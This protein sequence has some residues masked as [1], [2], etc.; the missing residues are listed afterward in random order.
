MP[1]KPDAIIPPLTKAGARAPRPAHLGHRQR[2]V[3]LPQERR[4]AGLQAHGVRRPRRRGGARHRA[5]L[6]DPAGRKVCRPP[7]RRVAAV[8]P[9]HPVQRDD[10]LVPA[11][12]GA[13]RGGAELLGLRDRGRRRRF[14]SAGDSRRR[15]RTRSAT[16][17]AADSVGT[18]ADP[19]S[20]RARGQPIAAAVNARPS[21]F[22][23]GRNS[24]SP[25]RLPSWVAPRAASR[26]TAPGGS[27]LG[28]GLESQ[29]NHTMNGSSERCRLLRGQRSTARHW[30]R[31]WRCASPARS[32]ER[33][34]RPAAR[35]RRAPAR[36]PRAGAVD[37]ARAAA[38]AA[39]P[40]L[41]IRRKA[42]ARWPLSG[43]PS[44]WLR[45]A[46][47]APL[48]LLLLGLL[49]IER[50]YVDQQVRAAAEID[51]A[52]LTDDLPPQPT[53]TRASP[54]S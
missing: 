18:G 12:E 54:S 10:G 22:V 6:D 21:C 53:A 31:A 36:R 25:R 17:S 51:A 45:L 29:G 2:T 37:R 20:D 32:A 7:R 49:F 26:P 39:A 47:L 8:V 9:A 38:Q 14:R 24:M 15:R 5:G 46:S 23:T 19:A 11:P 35:H 44:W 3:R 52:L 50:S 30:R 40:R 48:A 42:A 27:C 16:E 41:R 13:Q 1:G 28:E 34:R 4:E 33:S 43:P